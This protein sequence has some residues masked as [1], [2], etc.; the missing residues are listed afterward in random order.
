MQKCG[1]ILRGRQDILAPVVSALRGQ[2]SPSPPPFR[3]L[4][5]N[6]SSSDE[7]FVVFVVPDDQVKWR[8]RRGRR[9]GNVVWSTL[10]SR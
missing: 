6:C 3:R 9:P 7:H 2:A 8:G 4:C 10:T 5:V 1:K